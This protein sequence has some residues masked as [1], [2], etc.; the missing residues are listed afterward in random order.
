MSL[1]I[2]AGIQAS[3]SIGSGPQAIMQSV[4]GV[5]LE[6]KY[7]RIVLSSNDNC[8]RCEQMLSDR[9]YQRYSLV[10]RGLRV[11][12][13]TDVVFWVVL[14]SKE[15]VLADRSDPG[16]VGDFNFFGAESSPQSVSFQIGDVVQ[17]LQARGRLICPMSITFRSN[18]VVVRRGDASI[19]H[20]QLWKY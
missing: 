12:M 15:G 16:Y 6:S 19:E 3:D 8:R 20:I 1:I 18:N 4:K 2:T 11:T 17:N 7:T 13:E 10:L 9:E 14:N 5:S